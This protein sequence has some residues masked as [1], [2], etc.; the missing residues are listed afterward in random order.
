[1]MNG[2]VRR[3]IVASLC[4]V[5]GLALATDLPAA[6]GPDSVEIDAIY[7]VALNDF[8]IGTFSFKSDV[9]AKAYSAETDVRISFAGLVGWRGQTKTQGQLDGKAP[10]PAVYQFNFESPAKSGSVAMNFKDRKVTGLTILPE[11]PLPPGTLPLTAEHIKGVADPLSAVLS[12][13]R[14][15]GTNPCDRKVSIFDG[16]QRFDLVLSYRKQVAITETHPSGQPSEGVICKV[17]YVPIAG[18]RETEEL[19]ALARNNNISITFRPIPSAGL[20]VPH[21]VV[22]PT[23]A[24]DAVLTSSR[25]NIKAPNQGQIALIN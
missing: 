11:E 2:N 22:I 10:S 3:A 17:K 14:T 5:G 18:Y 25:V 24:G 7:K 13:V 15:E 20:M 16:K 6:A 19:R 4:A 23:V 12:L 21:A 9:G 1:M 8:E